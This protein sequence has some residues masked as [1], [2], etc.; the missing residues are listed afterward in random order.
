[1]KIETSLEKKFIETTLLPPSGNSR[2]F[3][4]PPPGISNPFRG[5]YG[6]FQKLHIIFYVQARYSTYFTADFRLKIFLTCLFLD[7]I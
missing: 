1:M 6:Y 2:A 4:P 5:G 7:Y 3:D